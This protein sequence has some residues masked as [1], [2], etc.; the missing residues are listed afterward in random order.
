VIVLLVHCA[1]CIVHWTMGGVV[2]AT[3]AVVRTHR[4]GHGIVGAVV[5]AAGVAQAAVAS[6][7]VGPRSRGF[8]G[9]GVHGAIQAQ[10]AG[11]QSGGLVLTETTQTH[12]R[13]KNEKKRKWG[14]R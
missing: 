3:R 5:E 1:G 4:H 10:R 14:Y 13:E 11:E 12:L 2:V 6:C 7:V 9:G 8:V